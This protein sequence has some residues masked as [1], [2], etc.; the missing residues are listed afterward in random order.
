VSLFCE[1]LKKME[2]IASIYYKGS[3]ANIC[4]DGFND[5]TGT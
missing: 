1:N 2:E 3:W 5:I 4:A